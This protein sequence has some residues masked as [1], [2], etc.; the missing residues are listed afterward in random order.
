MMNLIWS[1]VLVLLYIG[2]L[3]LSAR[4][5]YKQA[6][7]SFA[8]TLSKRLNVDILKLDYSFEQMIYF[9]SLP[10]NLPAI[11]EANREDVLIKLDYSSLFFPKLSGIHVMIKDKGNHLQIAYLPIKDFRLP[12]LDQMLEQGKINEAEYMRMGAFMVSHPSILT[13]IKEE[14]LKQMGKYSKKKSA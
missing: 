12:S 14:V 10:S 9:I 4:F 1:L 3:L 6:L 13:E 5:F 11:R 7:K 2:I 8:K